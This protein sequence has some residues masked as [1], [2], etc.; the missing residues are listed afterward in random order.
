MKM[1]HCLLVMNHL[2]CKHYFHYLIPG[3]RLEAK[4]GYDI[5]KK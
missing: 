1:M 5:I 3:T 2:L 4:A